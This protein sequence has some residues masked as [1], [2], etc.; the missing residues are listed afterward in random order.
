MAE[1]TKSAEVKKQRPSTA[2]KTSSKDQTPW[3]PPM[4]SSVKAVKPDET[5]FGMN[6]AAVPF[7]LSDTS[8]LTLQE[9]FAK[10]SDP[11]VCLTIMEDLRV[12]NEKEISQRL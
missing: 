10:C 6:K 5:T 9:K 3:Y 8:P 4:M 2:K 1:K 7:P 12:E 11:S